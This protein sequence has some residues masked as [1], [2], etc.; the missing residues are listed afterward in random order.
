MQP[1]FTPNTEGVWLGLE[2][3]AYHKAPGVS[4]SRLKEFD[5]YAS[6][7]HYQHRKPKAPSPDMQF[8]TVCH[9]AVLEPAKLDGSYHV[10]PEEFKRGE[11]TPWF[12]AH[13]DKPCISK[14]QEAGI[15][16][17]V[18]RVRRLPEFGGALEVGDH[19][20]S[21]FKRGPAAGLLLKCR[22]DLMAKSQA[23]SVVIFDLKKIQA[24]E[25]AKEDWE[26]HAIE[27]GYHIQA[28]SYLDITGAARFVFVCFDDDEPYDA[29]QW[30]P[31]AD[32]LAFGRNE[33]RRI[34]RTFA[35]CLRTDT[36]PGYPAGINDMSMPAWVRRATLESGHKAWLTGVARV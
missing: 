3:E 29:I 5:D 25:G 9:T 18:D 4:Q 6:P 26:K 1:T 12:N 36:W 19:E 17:I 21:H 28:G 10:A 30:E 23:G 14:E 34:L 2:A 32:L 11:K 7:L 8:G 33:Y 16:K 20:V 31:D 35:E 22:C 15:P 13:K 27:Y 24:G